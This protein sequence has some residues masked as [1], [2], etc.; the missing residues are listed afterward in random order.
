MASLTQKL[1]LGAAG[2][3]V[4][5][6]ALAWFAGSLQSSVPQAPAA[7]RGA[8]HEVVQQPLSIK[9]TIKGAL[10]AG[11]TVPVNAPF[12]GGVREKHVQFGDQVAQGDILVTMDGFEIETRLREAQSSA[13]KTAMALEQLTRWADSADV[14]RAKRTAEAAETSLA[15]AER[16]AAEART[17][18]E[19]GIVSRNEYEGLAEQRDA[20]RMASISARDDLRAALARGDAQNRRLAELDHTN[21]KLRLAELQTQHDGAVIRAAV[22]GIVMRPPVNA[23]LS[24]AIA[25]TIEPGARVARGQAIFVIAD[26]NAL[27][28]VGKADENDVNALRVGMAVEI[29]SDAFPGDPIAGRLISVSA[30]A[31]SAQTG[32]APTFEVRALLGAVEPARRD[33]IR[34]GMSARMTVTLRSDPK[35]VQIPLSAVRNA[36]TNP[37][38]QVLKPNGAGIS[39]RPITLGATTELG[40]EVLSGLQIGEKIALNR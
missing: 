17:L 8:F 5:L 27:V 21:A 15:K 11:K 3:V 9:A 36:S 35:A 6:G 24:G 38:V 20:Q 1:G 13:L 22:S 2:V 33:A 39:E 14:A 16:Q 12:D 34:I 30:E 25:T 40:V 23:G 31:D 29:E 19:R 10:A 28:V 32:K 26:V 18:M 37:T 7:Y 4:A